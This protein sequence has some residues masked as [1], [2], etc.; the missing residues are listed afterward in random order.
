M[1]KRQR[2]LCEADSSRWEM[3][4]FF[5]F[6]PSPR[7]CTFHI[8]QKVCLD[9]LYTSPRR[10]KEK[11]LSECQNIL[12]IIKIIAPVE[13]VSN[14]SARRSLSLVRIWSLSHQ[15]M[16]A[17]WVTAAFQSFKSPRPCRRRCADHHREC[18]QLSMNEWTFHDH[19]RV[20]AG[21][22]ICWLILRSLMMISAVRSDCV[23]SF[24]EWF[25]LPEW[26]RLYVSQSAWGMFC[27]KKKTLFSGSR[28]TSRS[29]I[30]HETMISRASRFS[31]FLKNLNS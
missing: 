23:V 14:V 19:V 22:L 9:S 2:C 6:S 28:Q 12:I 3:W 18:A 4:L 25:W 17:R 10:E 26:R 11:Y 30:R 31:L 7:F 20:V 15:F 21:Q 5:L 29:H 16:K 27:A 1:E 24:F 13:C 8:S